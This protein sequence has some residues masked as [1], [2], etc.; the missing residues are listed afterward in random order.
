MWRTGRQDRVGLRLEHPRG[1]GS[2]QELTWAGNAKALKQVCLPPGSR[3]STY[4]LPISKMR[5]LK[6]RIFNSRSTEQSL[7]WA[8]YYKRWSSVFQFS[9]FI[10]QKHLRPASASSLY[11]N[12]W[13]LHKSSSR[14]IRA[15][16]LRT[17]LG[18]LLDVSS[19]SIRQRH[20]EM[21][22]FSS[23]EIF[24]RSSWSRR[25]HLETPKSSRAPGCK[26]H[27]SIFSNG[28]QVFRYLYWM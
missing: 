15:R 21:G 10:Y 17:V 28:S 11:W 8:S 24:G 26:I 18:L 6:T 22:R 7:H 14:S 19:S 25:R 1:T 3:E 4:T 27:R 12:C 16:H 9:F 20:L 2:D 5:F 13:F 23:S